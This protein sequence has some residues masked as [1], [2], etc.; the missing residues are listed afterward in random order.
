MGVTSVRLQPEI[1]ESL[2]AIALK[3]H[4]S[5]GWLINQALREFIGREEQA[6]LRWQGTLAA[7]E[8]VAQGRVV[9]ESA[10]HEWLESWGSDGEKAAPSPGQ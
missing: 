9:S 4:R 5:K 8:S 3:L 10:V 1:E 7:L 6:A 2:E